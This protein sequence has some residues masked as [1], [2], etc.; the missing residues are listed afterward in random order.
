[1]VYNTYTKNEIE[2]GG[3]CHLMIKKIPIVNFQKMKICTTHN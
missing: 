2:R 3:D 1:M